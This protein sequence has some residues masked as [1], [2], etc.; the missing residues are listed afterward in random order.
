[1]A[2][3]MSFDSLTAIEGTQPLW[4]APPSGGAVDVYRGR[5]MAYKHLYAT[6]PN[7]RTCVDF[8]SRNLAHL[9][10]HV[11]R[12][13]S[14]TD[15]IRLTDHDLVRWLG[16]PNPSTTLYRLIENLIGDLGIY[17][18]A[19]WYK[20]RYA[21]GNGRP[22]IGLVRLPPD[23]MH[24]DG[25]L[26]ASGYTWTVA[27]KR[28]TFEL[29]EVCH[30]GGYNPL[31]TK[32]GLSP[33]ETLRRILAEEVA[34]GNHREAYW[35]NASRMEGIIERPLAAP[36]WLPEQKREW[37][38][39][40]AE[41]FAGATG[42]GQ[43]AVLEEGMTYRPASFSPKE[44][45]YLSARK[46]SR[47]ECAAAYQIPAPMVGILDHAT[48]SNITEQHK[49]TY[50]DTL[51]PWAEMITQAIEAQLLTEC[52]DQERIYVEFNI[53][54]KLAGSFEEQ[55]DSLLKA[56]GRPYMT[57]NEA[58]ARVNLPAHADPSADEIAPQQ[59]GPA[60]GVVHEPEPAP[61]VRPQRAEL[62]AHVEAA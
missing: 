42:S 9:G 34:A 15:R 5:T 10:L 27:G 4:N 26:L 11:F 18:N 52:A 20:V 19:Y 16:K 50:Q 32:E 58:R 43:V 8:L 29:D 60:L 44:S 37:R 57:P 1:M 17:F 23:E 59:G 24:V 21:D 13:V 39:Q 6:Q 40:W 48:F 14:D 31:N 56:T 22:A 36:R 3:V 62:P 2:I 45:E 55:A 35:L 53:A 51:G 47:E 12:R 54:A 38:K 25:S 46:L 41:R 61:V 33:L 7:I 28:R 49:H 30:F